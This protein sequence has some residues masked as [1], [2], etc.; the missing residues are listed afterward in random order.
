M[1]E[2]CLQV[3]RANIRIIG[4]LWGKIGGGSVFCGE[5]YQ[6]KGKLLG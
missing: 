1:R 2:R 5:I 3:E 6:K 4:K